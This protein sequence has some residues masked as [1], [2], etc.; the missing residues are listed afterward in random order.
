M[1]N[2]KNAVLFYI[3]SIVLLLVVYTTPIFALSILF[4]DGTR[5]DDNGPGDLNTTDSG[6]LDFNVSVYINDRVDFSDPNLKDNWWCGKS[7][8]WTYYREV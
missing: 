7:N 4:S 3:A 2:I 6:V 8:L 5:V 1:K